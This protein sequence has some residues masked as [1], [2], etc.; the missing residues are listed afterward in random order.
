MDNTPQEGTCGEGNG[1]AGESFAQM[2]DDALNAFFVRGAQRGD[3]TIPPEVEGGRFAPDANANGRQ[4][5]HGILST[6]TPE[7]EP[8]RAVEQAARIMPSS[9]TI[10]QSPPNPSILRTSWPL[11]TPPASG[12]QDT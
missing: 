9:V 10:P 2:A 7:S 6:G 12:L 4:S 11:T 3:N 1:T 8:F 5:G